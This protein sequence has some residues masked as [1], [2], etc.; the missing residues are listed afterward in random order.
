MPD[1]RNVLQSVLA[2]Y[3]LAETPRRRLPPPTCIDRP[4]VRRIRGLSRP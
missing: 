2:L 4:D 3:G 1:L